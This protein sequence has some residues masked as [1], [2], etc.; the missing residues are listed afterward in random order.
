VLLDRGLVEVDDRGRVRAPV[1]VREFARRQPDASTAQVQLRRAVVA[2]AEREGPRLYGSQSEPALEMLVA[3]VDALLTV[4]GWA[5][6]EQTDAETVAAGA[7]LLVALRRF[8]LLAS[9]L[10]EARRVLHTLR[11]ARSLRPVDR[12]RLGVLEGNLAQWTGDP[13]ASGLLESALADASRLDAPADRLLVS[14]WCSLAAAAAVGEDT[15]RAYA[16]LRVARQS[17]AASGEE[18]LAAL[19]RDL[20][21]FLAGQAGDHEGAA[22]VQLESLPAARA[23]GDTRVVVTLLTSL[24]ENLCELG[25]DA[26]AL[27]ACAEAFALTTR[28]TASPETIVFLVVQ[29]EVQVLAGEVAAA[30]GSCLEGLRS[31]FEDYPSPK[32]LSDGLTVLA[33]IEAAHG[34]HEAAAR[35]LGAVRQLRADVGLDPE[36]YV[37]SRLGRT[38]DT[39]REHL[40]ADRWQ[41]LT[42]VGGADPMATL[43]SLLDPPA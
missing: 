31:A 11:D 21:G 16:I 19:V 25:R 23:A 27:A 20:E 40:G 6:Q 14:G 37:D 12:A 34:R 22:R 30:A 2:L 39:T 7:D 26:D 4:L 5:A 35:L 3:D 10:P 29:A 13:E 28:L 41:V 24:A 1:P 32:L 33:V 42:A 8:W 38:A 9:R 43:R 15:D 17:A 18:D 36:G